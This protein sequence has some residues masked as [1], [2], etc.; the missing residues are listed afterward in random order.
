M[1]HTSSLAR[2]IQQR[3]SRIVTSATRHDPVKRI[4]AL[5]M[6]DQ[7]PECARDPIESHRALDRIC[8]ERISTCNRSADPA[9]DRLLE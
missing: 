3:R 4:P 2:Q 8:A 1:M 9:K 7:R 6:L 5:I